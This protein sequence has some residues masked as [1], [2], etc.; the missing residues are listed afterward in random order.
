[1]ITMH[2]NLQLVRA[3]SGQMIWNIITY[4]WIR[5]QTRWLWPWIV[6]DINIEVNAVDKD[7]GV[8]YEYPLLW[9]EIISLRLIISQ[10]MRNASSAMRISL[11]HSL[12]LDWVVGPGE[13]N[14][15]H[16]MYDLTLWK[17]SCHW[18]PGR[19]VWHCNLWM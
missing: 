4:S 14:R 1:M 15:W 16:S 5:V 11:Y 6:H 19:R 12:H 10:K 13:N 3:L 2:V 9:R 8:N 18:K 17:M 7:K